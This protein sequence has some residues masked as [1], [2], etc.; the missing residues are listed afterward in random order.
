MAD[1]IL[2]GPNQGMPGLV[3]LAPHWGQQTRGSSD[4]S[5]EGLWIQTCSLNHCQGN[6]AAENNE[7]GSIPWLLAWTVT[8]SAS[9]W[10]PDWNAGYSHKEKP[11]SIQ[12]RVVFCLYPTF[13]ITSCYWKKNPS[14]KKNVYYWSV[15]KWHFL[16]LEKFGKGAG[17]KITS[18]RFY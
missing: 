6:L 1:Q 4:C 15:G 9:P 10:Q 14:F 11:V 13:P 2:Y 5:S 8:L 16:S 3:V 7:L 12:A 17:N 18:K